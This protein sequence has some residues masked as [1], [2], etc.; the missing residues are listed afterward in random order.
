MLSTQDTE[1]E[2]KGDGQRRANKLC[3]VLLYARSWLAV[4]ER[5]KKKKKMPPPLILIGDNSEERLPF[6]NH[7][8]TIRALTFTALLI[9]PSSFL[10]CRRHHRRPSRSSA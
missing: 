10:L 6:T 1:E 7:N 2:N 3:T 5:E 8:R 9:S 4:Q